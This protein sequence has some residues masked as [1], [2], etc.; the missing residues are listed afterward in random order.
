MANQEHEG[1][2]RRQGSNRRKGE[3]R[4]QPGIR[5]HPK[6]EAADRRAGGRRKNDPKED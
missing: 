6:D 3:D 1:M 4:R 2:E 5:N